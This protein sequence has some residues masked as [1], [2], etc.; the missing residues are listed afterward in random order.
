M[1]ELTTIIQARS[2]EEVDR[3]TQAMATAPEVQGMGRRERRAVDHKIYVEWLTENP[4][5]AIESTFDSE[6]EPNPKRGAGREQ[7]R[8]RLA[9]L[10]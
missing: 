9:L 8:R 1:D 10:G 7:I 6:P 2:Q 5:V 3:I 4:P